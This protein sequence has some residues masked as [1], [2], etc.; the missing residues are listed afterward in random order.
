MTEH[1]NQASDTPPGPQSSFPDAVSPAAEAGSVPEIEIPAALMTKRRGGMFSGGKKALEE[2]NAELRQALDA[3]GVI[4][5][6]QIRQ[7]I[8]RLRT[9][10]Q[11]GV[12]EL[13]ALRDQVIATSDEAILQEVGVYQ[14]RHPLDTAVAFKERLA[15]V[16]TQIKA[17]AK[18]QGAVA[19]ATNWQVNGSAK[20]GSRMVRDFSKLM[21][22]AYNNE[23]DNAIRSM[24]AYALDASVQR[25]DK[26]RS[27][28]SRLGKTMNIN[29][30]DAYHRLRVQELELTADYLA[31]AAEE[32]E[33]EREEKARL[34][35]E[36]QARREYEREKARLAKRGCA[37]FGCAG[38]ATPR[39]RPVGSCRDGDETS[40]D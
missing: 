10:Q 2:E 35:E 21:L 24:K 9:E 34:R 15:Q 29:V 14:Y 39:R 26:V 22:R 7:D 4:E 36:E 25:L 13:A 19:G 17:M 37:L 32:K 23:A 20:E 16:Q 33:R 40:R 5:R 38:S 6:E 12:S 18:G 31:M 3:L 11:Q 27:T 8:V 30:T 1:R 28:I